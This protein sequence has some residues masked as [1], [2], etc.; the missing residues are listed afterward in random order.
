MN[1][2]RIRP[3]GLSDNPEIAAVIRHI[4]AEFGANKPGTV[5]FDPT[6]DFL[7]HL[8]PALD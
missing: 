3:I 1:K 7:Y 8:L 6:I 2:I 4:L 5:Y